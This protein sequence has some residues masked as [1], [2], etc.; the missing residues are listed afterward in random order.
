MKDISKEIEDKIS[1]GKIDRACDIS[2]STSLQ[3]RTKSCIITNKRGELL[4]DMDDISDR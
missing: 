2:K 1:I 3:N 4:I